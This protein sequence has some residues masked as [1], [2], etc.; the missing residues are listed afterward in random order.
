M[1]NS[2]NRKIRVYCAGKLN[3]MACDYTK[4]VSRMCKCA[5]EVQKCGFAVYVPGIDLLMGLI[6][7]D[8]EYNDY[9]DNSQAWLEVSDAVF[10]TPGWETSQG[11]KR[12]IGLAESLGI[13]VFEDL[14]T[15]KGYF[16]AVYKK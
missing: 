9:F 12:E 7:G 10:L 2:Q 16:N 11:T 15:M 8:Y 5:I 14:Y 1:S 13:P 4:N 6:A 3:D